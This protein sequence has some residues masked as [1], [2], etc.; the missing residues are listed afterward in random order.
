MTYNKQSVDMTFSLNCPN[1]LC[2]HTN[3]HKSRYNNTL[4]YNVS[5]INLI[6]HLM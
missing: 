1:N 4:R 6:N 2:W 3:D 5:L